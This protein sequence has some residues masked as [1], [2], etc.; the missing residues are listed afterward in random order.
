MSER[1]RIYHLRPQK[2]FDEIFK[3]YGVIDKVTPEILKEWGEAVAENWLQIKEIAEHLIGETEK[4]G[5]TLGVAEKK[6]PEFIRDVL[7]TSFYHL[8][9]LEIIE[10]IEGGEGNGRGEA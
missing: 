9:A 7:K 8:L 4:L 2:T 3:E 10:T 6:L 1:I 5:R